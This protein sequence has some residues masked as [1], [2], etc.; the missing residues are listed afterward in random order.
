MLNA[1]ENKWKKIIASSSMGNVTSVTSM[2]TEL[3]TVGETEI[4]TTTEMAIRL[5]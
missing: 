4:K 2:D 1:G 5:Q 3:H